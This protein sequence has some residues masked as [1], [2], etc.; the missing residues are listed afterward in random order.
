[1]RGIASLRN[2]ITMGRYPFVITGCVE[3]V[4]RALAGSLLNHA[5]TGNDSVAAPRYGLPTIQEQAGRAALR[6]LT[7]YS[8][9]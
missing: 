6:W 3:T 4:S 2:L 5:P 7:R 9:K 8:P 1:M